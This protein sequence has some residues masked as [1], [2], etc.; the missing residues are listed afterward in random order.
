MECRIF[1][2]HPPR[3]RIN[4][5]QPY[6]MI[7]QIP[8]A[9]SVFFGKHSR[10]NRHHWN[11]LSLIVAAL[12]CMCL[13]LWSLAVVATAVAVVWELTFWFGVWSF[14]RAWVRTRLGHFGTA[15]D[16]R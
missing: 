4:L 9:R 13:R 5:P 8:A 12:A 14:A 3:A 16:R 1:A 11:T 7:R 10:M 2:L 6:K 15:A